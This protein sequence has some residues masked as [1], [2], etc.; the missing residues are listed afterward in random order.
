VIAV[1]SRRQL[2]DVF[3]HLRLAHGIGVTELGRRVYADRGTIYDRESGRYG[4]HTEALIATAAV[5]GFDVALMPKRHPGVR[6]T[7]TGWPEVT[8]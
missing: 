4:F 7:G 8:G 2:A 6:P 3:R 5:F 1:I